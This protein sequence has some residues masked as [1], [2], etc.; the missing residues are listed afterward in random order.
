MRSE[1][2]AK[3]GSLYQVLRRQAD[4][5]KPVY[6]SSCERRSGC[7]KIALLRYQII[8]ERKGIDGRAKTWVIEK[9]FYF[10]PEC[11]DFRLH[12]LK[13]FHIFLSCL[14]TLLPLY[15]FLKF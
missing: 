8:G 7:H 3:L 4:M 14:H 6:P 15:A 13:S 1:E 9:I 5:K 12:S 10:L 2:V 11:I